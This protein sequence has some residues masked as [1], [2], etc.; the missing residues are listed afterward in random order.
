MKPG[1][2]CA[3]QLEAETLADSISVGF[4]RDQF[5]ALR[6]VRDCGG[7]FISVPDEAIL[8]A[9]SDLAQGVGVAAEPAGAVGLA[10]L[11]RLAGEGVFKPGDRAAVLVTGSGLK[12]V[13]SAVRAAQGRVVEAQPDW[14]AVE[15]ALGRLN[16]YE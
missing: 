9:M 13:A 15:R 2:T 11:R 10:G 6:A 16:S 3:N 12:D 14:P 4:P 5:K 1:P 7:R 8:R